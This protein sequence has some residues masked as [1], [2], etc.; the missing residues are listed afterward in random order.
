MAWLK[1]TGP[2]REKSRAIFSRKQIDHPIR[3]LRRIGRRRMIRFLEARAIA[4]LEVVTKNGYSRVIDLR[5]AV[6][7]WVP[8]VMR[9]SWL[10]RRPRRET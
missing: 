5:D 7:G 10:R 2:G 6:G 9:L 4:G 1:E 8:G 3:D